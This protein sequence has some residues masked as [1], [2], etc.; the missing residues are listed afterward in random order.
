[1]AVELIVQ[2]RSTKR[3]K[4]GLFASRARRVCEPCGQALFAAMLE[5]ME[6]DRSEARRSGPRRTA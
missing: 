2:A 5:A 1:V 6:V 3:P 4:P